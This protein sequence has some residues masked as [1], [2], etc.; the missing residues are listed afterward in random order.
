MIEKHADEVEALTREDDRLAGLKRENLL[1]R[2]K[3]ASMPTSTARE[4][5][6]TQIA[7]RNA[8]IDNLSF[9]ALAKIDRAGLHLQADIAEAKKTTINVD[10]MDSI[11]AICGERWAIWFTGEQDDGLWKSGWRS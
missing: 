8:V 9:K 11:G 5:K 10:R 1:E 6:R 2:L 7:C 3:L 4:W